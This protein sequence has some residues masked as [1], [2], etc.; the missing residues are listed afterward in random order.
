VSRGKSCGHLPKAHI[1]LHQDEVANG[2]CVGRAGSRLE[3]KP[4]ILRMKHRGNDTEGAKLQT[5]E[6]KDDK[7]KKLTQRWRLSSCR[8]H[9]SRFA[10]WRE[11]R[12]DIEKVQHL[13]N[14]RR[15]VLSC[16]RSVRAGVSGHNKNVSNREHLVSPQKLIPESVL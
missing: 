12:F 5:R 6:K 4:A 14:Q 16:T 11:G 10:I 13:W 15:V 3:H 1:G 8:Y 7:A 2:A 9:L